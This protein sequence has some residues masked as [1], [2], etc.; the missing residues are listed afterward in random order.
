[1]NNYKGVIYQYENYAE[2]LYLR[3]REKHFHQK[4]PINLV[5]ISVKIQLI[6]LIVKIQKKLFSEEKIL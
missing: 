2:F 6:S 5:C 3:E 1:M 4:N